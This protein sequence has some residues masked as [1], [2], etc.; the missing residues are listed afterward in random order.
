MRPVIGITAYREPARW[1]VW[2]RTADLIG[3]RYADA[4]ADA[5]GAPL[6]VPP[7]P[8]SAVAA[9]PSLA[10]L[11][12]AG[13]PDLDPATYGGRPH[14][15]AGPYRTD[16]D[17]AEL[18]LVRA[19]LDLRRPVLG[20]CRGAQVLNVACGGNLVQHIDGHRAGDGVFTPVTVRLEAGSW[21]ASVL[22]TEHRADC[23][24]HQALGRLGAD[25]R[26]VGWTA[27]GV[28]EAVELGGAGFAAAVQ[29]HP[30]ESDDRRLFAGFI[31]IA[32][33]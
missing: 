21:L 5:G 26:A 15:A 23:Y 6:I 16:R 14:P 3:T 32:S 10:A 28:V 29:W 33:R 11:V 31:S 22:G 18:S 27:D 25:L 2:D 12:L 7:L 8:Q 19:A 30:E 13:G 20:I 24:H 1:G 17:A 9:L 4:I